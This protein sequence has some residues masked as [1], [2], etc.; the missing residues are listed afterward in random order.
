MAE[1]V[2]PARFNGKSFTRRKTFADSVDD[3]AVRIDG[4]EAGRIMRKRYA[5]NV[6]LWFWSVTGP[7]DEGLGPSHG[8]EDT[9]EM[10]QTAF[11]LRFWKWRAWAASHP[12]KPNWTGA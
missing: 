1:R 11:K 8:E 4:L 7:Y 5:G 10:A 2:D 3:Y 12:G 6:M 9:L